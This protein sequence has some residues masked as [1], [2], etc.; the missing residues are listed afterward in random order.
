MTRV[1]PTGGWGWVLTVL[2]AGAGLGA[3][4]AV[5]ADGGH[6]TRQARPP[7][8]DAMDAATRRSAQ[9]EGANIA[10]LRARMSSR[11]LSLVRRAE[12]ADAV[13]EVWLYQ[14]RRQ[15]YV[16][17]SLQGAVRRTLKPV[18]ESEAWLNFDSFR[19][20]AA[21]GEVGRPVLL[22]HMTPGAPGAPGAPS[23]QSPAGLAPR[24]QLPGEDLTTVPVP[25]E[26][27]AGPDAVDAMDLELVRRA[28]ALY[29]GPDAAPAAARS[30]APPEPAAPSASQGGRLPGQAVETLRRQHI[31]EEL[32]RLVWNADTGQFMAS[33]T[34]QGRVLGMMRSPDR[35]TASAAFDDMVQQAESRAAAMTASAAAS[36]SSTAASEAQATTP[37]ESRSAASP[38]SSPSGKRMPKR[39]SADPQ[40]P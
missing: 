6:K 21:L 3:S 37:A 1:R 27:L 33:L 20:L 19:R 25:P 8:S 23:P 15:Y 9:A 18:N 24:P 28:Q 14:P 29:A 40:R 39:R 17:V 10:E 31:G 5:A 26:R 35:Q 38:R 32:A 30:G 36:A 12:I 16:S 11:D 34:R 13:I 22:G 2:M 7:A 4:A